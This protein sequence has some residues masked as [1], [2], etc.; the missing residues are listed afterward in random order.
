MSSASAVHHRSAR[1]GTCA[2]SR[3]HVLLS[4]DKL[5]HEFRLRIPMHVCFEGQIGMFLCMLAWHFFSTSCE[6]ST[7]ERLGFHSQNTVKGNFS[8]F[9]GNSQPVVAP[10]QDLLPKPAYVHGLINAFCSN[11]RSIMNKHVARHTVV[12]QSVQSTGICIDV[13][14][15]LLAVHHCC[16]CGVHLRSRPHADC[17]PSEFS[18]H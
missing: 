6:R 13:C 18:S 12:T 4:C 17:R 8:T 3:S 14:G 10:R 16:P 9:L 11:C 15:F 1:H 7:N 5:C 2:L